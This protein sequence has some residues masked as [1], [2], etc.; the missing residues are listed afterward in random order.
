MFMVYARL[1]HIG[2]RQEGSAC[3]HYC[4]NV[5][6]VQSVALELA[7]DTTSPATADGPPQEHDPG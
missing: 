4:V 5:T 1:A 7:T 6:L 2:E 3:D